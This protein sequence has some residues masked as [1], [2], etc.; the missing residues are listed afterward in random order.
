MHELV[1]VQEGLSIS[2]CKPG[3]V[4]EATVD[5]RERC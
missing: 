2:D 1:Q 5:A 4:T 3:N